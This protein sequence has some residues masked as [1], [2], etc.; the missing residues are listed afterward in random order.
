M[1]APE[2]ID[3][4]HGDDRDKCVE[5]QR[6]IKIDATEQRT[7][8]AAKTVLTACDSRPAEGDGIHH[9]R[10]GQ[11]QQREIDALAAQDQR[12]ENEG[13]ARDQHNRQNDRQGELPRQPVALDQP[14]GIGGKAKPCAMTEGNQPGAADKD[15]QRHAGD[16]EDHDLGGRGGAK[17]DDL[18][19]QGQQAE[20]ESGDGEGRVVALRGCH[21]CP[22]RTAGCARRTGRAAG[23]AGQAASSDR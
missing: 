1:K 5:R 6:R 17:P 11:R 8:D 10:E 14:C 22:T 18:H 23:T 20:P 12:P 4:H 3:H 21:H 9:G 2:A 16:G 7:P 13:N 19:E 15:I